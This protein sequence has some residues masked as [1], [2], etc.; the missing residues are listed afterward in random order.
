MTVRRQWQV[1]KVMTS[2]VV[3]LP[4]RI[5][6]CDVIPLSLGLLIFKNGVTVLLRDTRIQF[7]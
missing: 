4:R 1:V 5:L 2:G 3:H 6:Y 7:S